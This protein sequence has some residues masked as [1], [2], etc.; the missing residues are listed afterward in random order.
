MSLPIDPPEVNP[1]TECGYCGTEY[2]FEASYVREVCAACI[3]CFQP[4][5]R[6]YQGHDLNKVMLLGYGYNEDFD[7]DPVLQWG[8]LVAVLDDS[9]EVL[10]LGDEETT[11]FIKF[12]VRYM[13]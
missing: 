6:T 10:C 4:L 9:V 13:R 5:T 1:I 11:N 7:V 2:N 8:Q 12:D 3:D